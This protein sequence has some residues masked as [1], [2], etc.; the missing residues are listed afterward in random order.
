MARNNLAAFLS[1]DDGETWSG[2]LL[3]DERELVSY[4]DAVQT[5]DDQIYIIY[6]RERNVEKELL[7][8][9]IT[10]EDILQG[11]F[12]SDGSFTKRVISKLDWGVDYEI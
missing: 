7:L 9:R 6:D 3:L 5:P 10:E 11:R 12:V 2:P 8:A 1:T 4:P